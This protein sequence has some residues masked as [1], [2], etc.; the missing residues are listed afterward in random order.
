M[1]GRPGHWRVVERK[2][3]PGKG[4]GEEDRRRGGYDQVK[5]GECRE[6]EIQ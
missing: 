2:A 3:E 4:M 6:G 1:E 5:R